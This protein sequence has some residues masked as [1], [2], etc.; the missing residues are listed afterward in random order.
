MGA[1]ATVRQEQAI[2]DYAAEHELQV[3]EQ[4]ESNG[5]CFFSAC[6]FQLSLIGRVV[7]AAQM[8]QEVVTHVH[9]MQLEQQGL[10]LILQDATHYGG[11]PIGDL[12]AWEAYMKQDRVWADELCLKSAAHLY[13][14]R[15]KVV[16]AQEA[17]N[18]VY[19]TI[20]GEGEQMIVLGYTLSR[21][22]YSL[23][24]MSTRKKKK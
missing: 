6:S 3:N 1:E 16:R 5:N 20:Y 12:H 23:E 17:L 18:G 14:I 2:Y 15:I 11:Q 13:G 22:Y 8:R 21:H 9:E 19:E 4:V 7:P 24:P 10:Q